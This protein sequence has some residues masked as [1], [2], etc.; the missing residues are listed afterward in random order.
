[1]VLIVQAGAAACGLTLTAACKMFIMEPFRKHEEEKQA[2]ARL[3]SK[4]GWLRV[5]F[6]CF[7]FSS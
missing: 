4:F 5:S 3:V 6:V 1:V 7:F 2:Y